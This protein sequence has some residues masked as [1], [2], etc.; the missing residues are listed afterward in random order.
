VQR[1]RFDPFRR[2]RDRRPA[3]LWLGRDVAAGPVTVLAL[4]D[5]YPPRV[6]AGGEWM[7]H[8]MLRDSVRRGH[9][10]IVATECCD[11][12]LVFDGVEVCPVDAGVA[13]AGDAELV[14]SHLAY[15]RHAVD[16]AR[17]AGL[18][19]LYLVHND[20]QVRWWQI[21]REDVSAFVW[22]SEWIAAAARSNDETWRTP[23]TI[24]RPPLVATDYAVADPPPARRE[25]VA[26][27]NPIAAKGA[28]LFY[29]VARAE[30][31]RRF[32]AVEGAYG[33][34]QRPN[35]KDTNVV[36]QRQ[37]HRFAA[38]VLARTR[39]LLV[40]SHYESWGRVAVEALAAG[41]PVIATPT[42]GLVEALGPAGV[43][44]P[45]NDVDAWRHALR[46]LDDPARYAAQSAV[47]LARAADLDALGRGDLE[48]WDRLVRL[49]AGAWRTA[50]SVGRMTATPTKRYD[51]WRGG[52]S[53]GPQDTPGDPRPL[54]A[55]RPDGGPEN[56]T[57][58]PI[59]PPWDVPARATEVVAG[60][61][62]VE[63]AEAEARAVAAFAREQQR[64]QPRRSVLAAVQAVLGP[65]EIGA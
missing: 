60:L 57:E 38:D 10:V 35:P 54:R 43:F 28:D 50:A 18:P 32:L 65:V 15:T 8:A 34:Q 36:W 1:P 4:V 58:R 7:L 56:A 62:A 53:H 12:P 61:R 49:A 14:V 39:V 41:V 64:P 21:R 5:R 22:N 13:A 24:I 26:M 19:L 2:V 11:D 59:L 51:P 55:I 27:V 63:G 46:D 33:S 17:G 6:N 48:R 37:T 52:G 30:K 25:F 44:A 45:E 20:D 23:G 42:P 40:P 9:R 47:A 31:A 29:R 16:Y 3:A